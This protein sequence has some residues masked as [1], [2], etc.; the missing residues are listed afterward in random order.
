MDEIYFKFIELIEKYY[1]FISIVILSVVAINCFKNLDALPVLDWDEARHG[2]SAYEMVKNK[3]YI[4]NTY[5]YEKDYYN[6]KPPLSFWGI[7]LGFKIFGVSIFAMRFYSA[8]SIFLTTIIVGIFVYKRFGRIESLSTIGMLAVCSPLYVFHMGRNG[9]ADG[10]YLLSFTLS[11]LSMFY[12]KNNKKALYICGLFF[13]FAFLSKS[14]HAVS[15]AAIGGLYL[16]I[17]DEIKKIN[18]KEWILFLLSFMLPIGGWALVRVLKDGT[19]F[20]TEMVRY[21]LIERSKVPLEGHTGDMWYYFDY[22]VNNPKTTIMFV[23]AIIFGTSILYSNKLKGYKNEILA[24]ILWVIIPFIIFT[25]AETK[26]AW[27]IIPVYIP[28]VIL[29]GIGLG[30]IL[31]NKEVLSAIRI[32]IIILFVVFMF[33]DEKFI[34]RFIS[35]PMR[36]PVQHFMVNNIPSINDIKGIDAYMEIENNEWSQ[37]RLFLGEIL[38]DL[39]CNKGGVR[40]FLK[41]NNPSILIINDEN[42]KLYTKELKDLEVLKA[43]EGFYIIKK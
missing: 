24:F 31:K 25:K 8:V 15:I 33:R 23:I 7:I 29:S 14:W 21:D 16:L 42:Y 22:I 1:F 11:M 13:A 3:E 19:K 41:N 36:E 12:I 4:I 10:L 20:L 6:L 43:S 9:D 30:R 17:T 18:L 2:V 38:A 35:Y 34:Y 32:I 37:G 28:L 5:N 27:Y 39:K 40:G 26:L